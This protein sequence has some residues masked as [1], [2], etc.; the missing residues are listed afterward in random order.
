MHFEERL[1]DTFTP[2]LCESEAHSV[3]AWTITAH[4]PVECV[5]RN[6]VFASM[7]HLCFLNI[8]MGYKLWFI[9]SYNKYLLDFLLS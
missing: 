7:Y 9:F 5:K 3:F 8:T 2:C 6:D 1:Q 4:K